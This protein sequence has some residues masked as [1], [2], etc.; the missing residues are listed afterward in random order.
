MSTNSEPLLFADLLR[1]Y[2]QRAGLTQSELADAAGLGVRGVSDLE[3]GVRTTPRTATVERLATALRLAD[4]E[5]AIFQ[6]AARQPH[7][8]SPPVTSGAHTTPSRCPAAPSLVGRASELACVERLLNGKGPPALLLAGEPG[9]G[10]TRLLQEAANIAGALGWCVL[11]GGCHR[12]SGLEAYAPLVE[13]LARYLSGRSPAQQRHDLRG[14]AWLVRLL[15]ELAES[16]VVPSSTWT[17][18]S[19]QDR[20]LMFAAAG[21][22]L[23]N[24]AGPAGTLLV[25]DDL[26]WAGADALDLLAW[27]VRIESDRP[28]RVIGAYR[29]TEVRAG[30]LLA[31]TLADLARDGL[32]V[33]TTLAPLLPADAAGLLAAVVRGLGRTWSAELTSQVVRRTGGVPYFLVSCAQSP[34]IG[35]SEWTPDEAIPW[36]VRESIHQRVVVLPD[37]AQDVI[38]VAAVAG[39]SISRTILVTIAGKLGHG[40]EAV[41]RGLEE[42]DRARLLL[43]EERADTY[44]FAHDLIY[45]VVAANLSLARRKSLHLRLAKS[46]ERL[47]LS[48]QRAAEVAWHFREAGDNAHA[49]PYMVQAGDHAAVVLARAEAEAHYRAALALASSLGDNAYTAEIHMHLAQMFLVAMC[50]E[51]ALA[52]A[53]EAAAMYHALG[54]SAGIEWVEAQT[55]FIR[56]LAGA[57]VR[58]PELSQSILE[59]LEMSAAPRQAVEMYLTILH[60][61]YAT[62]RYRD[63]VP[64]AA[65]RATAV[66]RSMSPVLAQPLAMAAYCLLFVGLSLEALRV[67]EEAIP[68]CEMAGESSALTQVLHLASLVRLHAGEFG[69]GQHYVEWAYG[70]AERLGDMYALAF[71]SSARSHVAFFRGAW[72]EA[73]SFA[74]LAVQRARQTGFS[75]ALLYPLFEQGRMRLVSGEVEPARAALLDAIA[76]AEHDHETPALAW[77]NV[78]LAEC[79]LAEGNTM[80]AR[81]RLL[82][83]FARF[84]IEEWGTNEALPVLA[85]AHVELGEWDNAETLLSRGAAYARGRDD[86]LTLVDTLRIQA[87]LALRRGE[88]PVGAAALEESLTLCRA[89]PCPYAEAKALYVYGLLHIAVGEPARARARFAQV[90][91]ICTRLGERLYAG[92]VERALAALDQD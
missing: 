84:T 14:C 64:F 65:R 70:A 17:R 57:T 2:R 44:T 74:E 55:V 27:L 24:V 54:D 89:M 73:R 81:D 33:Q 23:A 53:E 8:P 41:V 76:A 86:R 61:Y 1:R 56:A 71:F 48:K 26:Q 29:S 36:N 78:L 40:E 15:P 52:Q 60:H 66:A 35:A 42:A 4:H 28:L 16:T 6:A 12:R 83:L 20:R 63:L 91:A 85:E 69:A 92:R 75:R 38:R 18:S 58:G 88:W 51:D 34:H 39:R 37:E 67:A 10:K 82:A 62:G 11:A 31:D 9:I 3:R 32:I 30:T 68:L 43:G 77:M 13:T 49:L 80:A 46:L 90:L 87:L 45:E 25:L 22:F 47:P 21:R 7:R 5:R 79:D 19:D 50:H 59:A 72:D